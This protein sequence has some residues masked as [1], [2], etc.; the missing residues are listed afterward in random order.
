[1]S[2]E[3]WKSFTNED[4]IEQMEG[5]SR[6]A[7]AVRIC[8]E[9][10]KAHND[11]RAARSTPEQ[12]IPPLDMQDKNRLALLMRLAKRHPDAILPYLKA[13]FPGV[14]EKRGQA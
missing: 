8:L 6:E 7:A 5:E 12:P 1:M 3:L 2:A 4:Q 13:A 11:S 14:G 10:L 9:V